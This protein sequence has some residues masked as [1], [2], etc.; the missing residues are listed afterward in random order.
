MS[1]DFSY[2]RYAHLF[3]FVFSLIVFCFEFVSPIQAATIT[4]TNEH[5]IGV[6][7][8][9]NREIAVKIAPEAGGRIISLIDKAD[10]IERVWWQGKDDPHSGLLDDK[11]GHTAA[12]FAASIEQETAE[13]VVV[14]LD[15]PI[16]QLT[17]S[18]RLTL[19]EG[20]TVLRCEYIYVNHSDSKIETE[21][22]VRN[23]FL[24]GGAA[25]SEDLIYWPS[26]FGIESKPYP[27]DDAGWHKVE[28]PWCALIDTEARSGFALWVSPEHLKRFYSW[29]DNSPAYPTLEWQLSLSLDPGQTATV[30][31]IISLLR[32]ISGVSDVSTQA[33]VHLATESA[34][35][36]LTI[37]ASLYPFEV[38]RDPN[39]DLR[40]DYET[41]DRIFV[42]GEVGIHLENCQPGQCSQGQTVYTAPSQ[43]TYVL[44]TRVVSRP[45]NT[46]NDFEI[47][48]IVGHSSGVYYK[49]RRQDNPETPIAVVTDVDVQSGYLVHWG[50]PE[51]PFAK[52]QSLALWMGTD[53]YESLELD[54]LAL[55]DMGLTRAEIRGDLPTP[56]FLLQT[57]DGVAN[58]GAELELEQY[59]IIP[60]DSLGLSQG[61][62]KA[63]WLTLDSRHLPVGDYAFDI[64]ISPENGTTRSIHVLLHVVNAQR[65]RRDQAKLNLYHLYAYNASHFAEHARLMTSHYCHQIMLHFAQRVWEHAVTVTPALD[66]QIDVNFS[67]MDDRLRMFLEAGYDEVALMSGS[68]F[69]DKWFAAFDGASE[70]ILQNAQEAFKPIII[71]HLYDV[72]FR[73]VWFYSIDEPSVNYALSDKVIDYFSACRASSPRLKMHMTMNHYAPVLINELNQFMDIYTPSRALCQ[74]VLEDIASGAAS[75]DSTDQVGF[76][77]GEFMNRKPD[78]GRM[79]G[80]FAAYN[81]LPFYSIFA[82][83]FRTSRQPSWG[84]YAD[85]S[86]GIVTTPPFECLRDGYEDYAYWKQFCHMLERVK[87]LDQ[88]GLTDEQKL[89]IDNALAL[90]TNM[91][92]TD[93]D[94]VLHMRVNPGSQ[95][96]RSWHSFETEDRWQCLQ[97]KGMVVQQIDALNTLF[98]DQRVTCFEQRPD[99]KPQ[100]D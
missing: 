91:F 16:G 10:G 53:E 86:Q 39:V 22:M 6:I 87:D 44:M 93:A 98:Q 63:F 48:I 5:G 83:N 32:G 18:K 33:A 57:Q 35:N 12:P 67:R 19:V 50:G 58:S 80:W 43:G 81:D 37:K 7:V 23:Y 60:G 28:R 45:N 21:P 17:H 71:Q 88:T 8:L 29:A 69:H 34:G 73:E 13:C 77:C 82:Y 25:G 1:G 51:P 66:N 49:G 61:D 72:G 76:Y 90:R 46:L 20:E 74:T 64:L 9:E 68:F 11:A 65:I 55:R 70:E 47:P 40:F 54:V 89:I 56:T 84:L 36:D 31:V 3:V 95:G 24:A 97:A 2:L 59:G 99:H 62:H 79:D 38:L 30:P 42:W 4:S 52:A 100:T 27:Y 78:T 96:A 15:S 75:I 85:S 94:A 14:R 41:L 92:G 26:A